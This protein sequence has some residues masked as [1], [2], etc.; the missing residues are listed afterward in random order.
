M[1]LSQITQSC[2]WEEE[3]IETE[4]MS[5]EES[6]L[7]DS[8]DH[9]RPDQVVR[10]RPPWR[11]PLP[12]AA[13]AV[14]GVGVAGMG[15]LQMVDSNQLSE[16]PQQETTQQASTVEEL[17]K[18]KLTEEQLADANSKLA[19]Q[20]QQQQLDAL[21]NQKP[22]KVEPKTVASR[23]QPPTPQPV[24]APAPVAFAPRPA[25][26]SSGPPVPRVAYSQPPAPAPAP[27][28]VVSSPQKSDMEAW[29][30]ASGVGS[31]GQTSD[32]S[33]ES[34]GTVVADA[35]YESDYQQAAYENDAYSGGSYP[36]ADGGMLPTG[37]T[38]E[39]MAADLT[40]GGDNS[41]YATVAVAPTD[42]MVPPAT[43][44]SY[45]VSYASTNQ[46][47]GEYQDLVA[48]GVGSPDQVFSDSSSSNLSQV[49]DYYAQ[50]AQDSIMSGIA[51]KT[52]P[53]GASAPAELQMPIAWVPGQNL[54]TGEN[55]LIKLDKPI[56]A[57]D[58]S[59]ALPAGT[60]LIGQVTTASDAGLL[61]M[62]ATSAIIT[63]G[64]QQQEISL[65][66]GAITIL[67]DKGS[68]LIAKSQRNSGGLMRSLSSALLAGV[69][70]AAQYINRPLNQT[71]ISNDGGTYSSSSNP[72]PDLLAGLIQG[73]TQSLVSDLQAR[74]QQGLQNLESQ[75]K[76]F[77]LKAGTKLKIYAGDS[78]QVAVL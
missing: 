44:E 72:A 47:S 11:R 2:G 33:A 56:M 28:P 24:S 15:L 68:P 3:A 55:Y 51:P 5:V 75:P 25:T 63:T 1:E 4:A 12:R 34:S 23:V 10:N 20:T 38:G 41:D 62:T 16:K 71:T 49:D 8:Q 6:T 77:T 53:I 57:A 69:G 17:P 18:G 52:I 21:K 40:A 67:A 9:V 27:A 54:A 29:L 19:L 31:Y 30:E 26:V 22:L 7:L 13:L 59:E 42:P 50:L 65:P 70:Q 61:S 36:V 48:S 66:S 45:D 73:S 39:A 14:A 43:N 32:K 64:G 35:S 46:A 76:I 78:I 60:Q 74:N 58:G 37:G